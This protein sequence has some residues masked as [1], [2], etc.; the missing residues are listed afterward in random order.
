MSLLRFACYG[1]IQ[2]NFR[3][4]SAVSQ[5]QQHHY[6]IVSFQF[7]EDLNVFSFACPYYC[8]DSRLVDWTRHKRHKLY[9]SLSLSLATMRVVCGVCAVRR[10]LRASQSL[11]SICVTE[12]RNMMSGSSMRRISCWSCAD[13]WSRL[14]LGKPHRFYTQPQLRIAADVTR[15]LCTRVTRIPACDLH[16]L[17]SESMSRRND[18]KQQ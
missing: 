6:I 17:Q 7:T 11:A 16:A 15:I 8:I 4:S 18:V 13:S 5:T 2:S 9:T 12:L 14:L 3:S 10:H 1:I